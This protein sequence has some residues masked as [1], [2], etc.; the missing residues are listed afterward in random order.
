MT[1]WACTPYYVAPEVLSRGYTEACDLWSVGVIIYVLLSGMVPFD[2][3][4]DSQV[5]ESVKK[6]KFTYEDEVWS[7]VS[8][9]A[10]NLIDQLLVMDPSKRLTAEQA[11][12]H[13]WVDKMAPNANDKNL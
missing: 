4:D 7:H 11:L 12:H 10:K 5:L 13:T 2:G 3:E 9:D 1:T 8:A 6:G